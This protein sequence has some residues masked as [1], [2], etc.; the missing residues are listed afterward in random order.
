MPT[1]KERVHCQKGKPHLKIL[2]VSIE[3]LSQVVALAR[4]P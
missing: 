4:I 3:P 2:D 1:A